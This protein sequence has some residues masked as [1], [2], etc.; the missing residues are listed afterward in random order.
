M[1]SSSRTQLSCLVRLRT[2]ISEAR[3]SCSFGFNFS[4]FISFTAATSSTSTTWCAFQT[5]AKLPL[6][7]G[8][9]RAHLSTT[10]HMPTGPGANDLAA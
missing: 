10:L 4:V 8:C 6:P 3:L 1:R 5:M 9:S 2:L 7:I